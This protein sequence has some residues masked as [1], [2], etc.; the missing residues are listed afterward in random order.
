[1]GYVQRYFISQHLQRWRHSE[2]R[3]SEYQI[4]ISDGLVIKMAAINLKKS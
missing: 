4:Q 2:L 3:A 1:M